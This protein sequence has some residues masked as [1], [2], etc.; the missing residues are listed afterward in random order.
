MKI[1]AEENGKISKPVDNAAI[2]A[3]AV[4]HSR[5]LAVGVIESVAQDKQCHPERIQSE[6]AIEKKMTGND[7]SQRSEQGDANRREIRPGKELREA[8]ADLAVKVDIEQAFNIARF[9][10]CLNIQAGC[11]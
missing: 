11:G 7:A 8:I 10:S 5:K 3:T 6:M 2:T 1:D 9:V 4:R